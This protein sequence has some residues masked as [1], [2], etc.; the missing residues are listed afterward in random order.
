LYPVDTIIYH[1]KHSAV[2]DTL[3]ININTNS[4]DGWNDFLAS[5]NNSLDPLDLELSRMR[6]EVTGK[7]M[8]AL[9]I[10]LLPSLF[11]IGNNCP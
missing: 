5:L 7:E 9:V 10:V 6:N 2:D 1:R 8:Y 3:Q 4:A 11:Q